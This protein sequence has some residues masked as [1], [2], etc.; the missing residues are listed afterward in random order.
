[1]DD[2]HISY[3]ADLYV[4][5]EPSTEH[6]PLSIDLQVVVFV[7]LQQ[8]VRGKRENS[9]CDE[10]NPFT[11]IHTCESRDSID[12]LRFSE[13]SVVLFSLKDVRCCTG[14]GL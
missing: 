9:P 5:Q 8:D 11:S 3:G 10:V 6:I 1:M 13:E 2:I 12:R 4:L 7:R 14:Y